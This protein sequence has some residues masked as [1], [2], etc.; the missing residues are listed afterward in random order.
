MRRA[1]ALCTVVLLVPSLAQAQRQQAPTRP[2]RGLFGGGPPADPH[3]TRTELSL[4]ANLS[5]G[6]DQDVLATSTQP[7]AGSVATTGD[8]GLDYYFGRAARSFSTVGRTFVTSYANTGTDPLIGGDVAMRGELELGRRSHLTLS[9]SFSYAPSLVLGTFGLLDGAVDPVDLPDTGD[10]SG[11]V[12]QRSWT[13]DTT[14]SVDRRF[15]SRQTLSGTYMYGHRTYLDDD[16]YDVATHAVNAGYTWSITTTTGIL[17]SY[18]LSRSSYSDPTRTGTS[19]SA[20]MTDHSLLFG[21]DYTRRLSRTRQVQLSGSVGAS[22]VDTFNSTSLAPVSYWTPSA[23]GTVRMDFGQTWALSGDYR[24]GTNVLQGVSLDTFSTHAFSV[25][26]DGAMGH[27]IRAA[28]STAFSTGRSGI[29]AES[30]F[31]AFG[32]TA[33]FNYAFARC[34]AASVNYDFYAYRMR[35]VT[36]PG[37]LPSNYDRNSIRVGFS[38]WLP[39]VGNYSADEGGPPSPRPAR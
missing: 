29:D 23:V 18:D 26:A 16:G 20:P 14:V 35:Q 37:E 28:V 21:A 39:L 34:C 25:R 1:L 2:Y 8:I 38:F 4:S 15:T 10:I 30:T 36:L 31:R 11:L 7:E 33:Q 32:S 24:R 22:Y 5:G 17:A 12:D 19:A 9:Q 6:Y 27:R 3:R 13:G